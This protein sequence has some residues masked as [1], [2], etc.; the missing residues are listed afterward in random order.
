MQGDI[1][2]ARSKARGALILN[3]VAIVW[4][5]VSMVV[6][7]AVVAWRVVAI[8]NTCYY[9]FNYVYDTYTYCY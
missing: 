9:H 4:W 6:Y 5:I 1:D 7:G 2:G 8:D 3:V